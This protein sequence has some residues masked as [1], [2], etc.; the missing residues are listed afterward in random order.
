VAAWLL[1]VLVLGGALGAAQAERVYFPAS[2]SQNGFVKACREAGAAPKREK[3][4]VVSCTKMDSDGSAQRVTCNFKTN[5]CWRAL[6]E[7]QS[8]T[9]NDN[10]VDPGNGADPG[11][12]L[13]MSGGNAGPGVAMPAGGVD[14]DGQ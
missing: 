4:R 11:S 14:P 8:P 1:A 7:G 2:G 9:R 6:E 13:D 5:Q 10:A 3:S 12:A